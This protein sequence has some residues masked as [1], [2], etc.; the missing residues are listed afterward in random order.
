V[1]EIFKFC[2]R[3]ICGG[4]GRNLLSCA[5][6]CSRQR[7][8]LSCE[9]S[10]GKG[11]SALASAGR[12]TLDANCPQF[13]PPTPA[14]Y[15]QAIIFGWPRPFFSLLAIQVIRGGAAATHKF[16]FYH[17]AA[18]FKRWRRSA[19]NIRACST[20]G[21]A[22]YL[23]RSAEIGAEMRSGNSRA[24]VPRCFLSFSL[25]WNPIP[26]L[27]K[28]SARSLLLFSP[29][30]PAVYIRIILFLLLRPGAK[31][32]QRVTQYCLR[33][34]TIPVERK[35]CSVFHRAQFLF[36]FPLAQYSSSGHFVFASWPGS[37][38]YNRVI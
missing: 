37:K 29:P 19:I 12:S 32:K 23:R 36:L 1:R 28:W 11:P 24:L 16:F 34:H 5:L 9:I 35:A 33:Q 2:Q 13:Q 31:H 6:Q 27:C 25:S 30:P 4:L 38:V 3:L 7:G 18:L 22:F 10:I 21:H 8:A 20:C 14:A 26:T 17:S 15:L